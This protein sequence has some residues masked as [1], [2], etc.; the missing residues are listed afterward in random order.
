MEMI[1][2]D[3]RNYKKNK[4]T[5]RISSLTGCMRTW[6]NSQYVGLRLSQNKRGIELLFNNEEIIDE[7]IVKLQEFKSKK[8]CSGI[9]KFDLSKDT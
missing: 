1:T 8:F 3:F 2:Y 4:D 6:K 7:L 9:K 5:L